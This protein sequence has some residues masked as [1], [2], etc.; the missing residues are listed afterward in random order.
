M[1]EQGDLFGSAVEL[2]ARLCSQG[3]AGG[4]VVSSAVREVCLGKGFEFEDCGPAELKG[5]DEPVRVY[6]VRPQVEPPIS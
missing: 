3:G 1:S 5:F 4:I 6:R 2:A